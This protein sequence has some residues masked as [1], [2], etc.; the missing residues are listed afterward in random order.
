MDSSKGIHQIFRVNGKVYKIV[1]DVFVKQWNLSQS[2][3][4]PNFFENVCGYTCLTALADAF[5]KKANTHFIDSVGKNLLRDDDMICL[6][7]IWVD[8][9]GSSIIHY[10]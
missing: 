4:W 1:Q 5:V 3:Y 2:E 9:G 8:L 6:E 7:Q 10:K